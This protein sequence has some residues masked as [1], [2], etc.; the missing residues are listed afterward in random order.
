[1]SE[2]VI[3]VFFMYGAEMAQLLYA[4]PNATVPSWMLTCHS[5]LRGAGRFA[6][7]FSLKV[8]MSLEN[9]WI[10]MSLVTCCSTIILS[11]LLMNSMGLTLSLR[12]CLMTVSVWGMMPSTAQQRM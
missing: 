1:M 12:A 2:K 10:I 8:A 3:P 5:L 9:L 4:D 6:L 7:I 11:T